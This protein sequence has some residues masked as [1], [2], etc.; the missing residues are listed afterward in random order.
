MVSQNK[1]ADDTNRVITHDTNGV[2]VAIH[3]KGILA[4][5]RMLAAMVPVGTV[6]ISDWLDGM[7]YRVQSMLDREFFRKRAARKACEILKCS[8]CIDLNNFGRHVVRGRDLRF[9]EHIIGSILNKRKLSPF[10]V[11]VTKQDPDALHAVENT[12]LKIW[13]GLAA[14]FLSGELMSSYLRSAAE[15]KRRKA[16]RG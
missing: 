12:D 7:E 6:E 8:P 14:L 3:P 10:P 11:V 15:D 1:L 13:A 2:L 16:K 9:A 5:S 4:P